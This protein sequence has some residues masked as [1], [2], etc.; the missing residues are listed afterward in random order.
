MRLHAFRD[1]AHIGY[2]KVD[3]AAKGFEVGNGRPVR[4]PPLIHPGFR[5]AGPA[6]GVVAAEESLARVAALS[7][8]LDPV[9]TGREFGSESHF[10]VCCVCKE[11]SQTGKFGGIGVHSS[12]SAS[13]ANSLKVQ[14][15]K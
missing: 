8:D 10:C 7:P 4:C 6:M 1:L 3:E 12:V 11:S 13:A 14:R 5:L 9:D 15:W 2:M